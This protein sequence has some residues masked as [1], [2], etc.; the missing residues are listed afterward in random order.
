MGLL[1]STL[2]YEDIGQAD[3]V[4]EAVFEE[5]GVKEAVFR[6]LDEVMK[7]GAILATNT[8]TLDVDK[9]AASPA[10]AGRDRHAFLQP[11]QRHEA[12][13]NRARQGHRQG[14]A[15]HRAGAVQKLKKTGVVSG[16][17]DGF[18][19][20]RM[21]EQYSR[22][23][24]FLLEEG[25]LPSRSTRQ[26]RNSALPWG[27]SAWATWPATTSAGR[28]A[29]AAMSKAG[30]QYSK[31]ADLLCEMGRLARNRRWLVRLQGGRPQ[32]VS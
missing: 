6:K 12:A 8:S 15:G 22:Q 5:M 16:V 4:V 18:I 29:S 25:A 23:A 32:G 17:C 2:A 19:G 26:P 1:S 11:G 30:D 24:G 20:N 3:I 21:I 9:I 31:T 13:G 14:R 10:P 28:S 7:P 27:R